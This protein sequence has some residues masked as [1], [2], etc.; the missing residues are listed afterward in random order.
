MERAAWLSLFK[1]RL[2]T[3][4]SPLSKRFAFGETCCVM[5]EGIK[6]TAV[7]ANAFE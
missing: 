2:I 5:I 7:P 1:R 6:Q 4:T 3:A